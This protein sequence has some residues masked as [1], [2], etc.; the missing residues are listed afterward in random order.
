[1]VS[2]LTWKNQES[3][4]YK[5]SEPQTFAAL[6]SLREKRGI[7]TGNLTT[8]Y[9]FH[10]E[11]L[12][13]NALEVEYPAGMTAGGFLDPCSDRLQMLASWDRMVLRRPILWCW[14]RIMIPGK[15]Q[16]GQS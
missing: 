4:H 11:D 15:C 3:I 12:T 8:P 1:M 9:I 2:M 14:G 10:W 7:V 13:D 6:E 5:S 16:P